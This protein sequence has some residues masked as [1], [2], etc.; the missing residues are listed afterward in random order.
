MQ[1][2]PAAVFPK[3]ETIVDFSIAQLVLAG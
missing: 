1:Q 3:T 2:K